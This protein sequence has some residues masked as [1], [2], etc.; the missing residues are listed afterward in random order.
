M[1]KKIILLSIFSL[2]LVSCKTDAKKSEDNSTTEKLYSIVPKTTK[3]GWTAYKT[4]DKVAVDGEFTKV[5]ITAKKATT[6]QELLNDLE[7]SIPVSSLFS[8]NE[9]RDTK[10][11]KLFFGVMENT[12]LLSGKI[13]VTS[14]NNG[15][16]TVTMNS[17]TNSFPIEYIKNGQMI[18]LSGVLNIDNFNGSK[19]MESLNKAC[20]EL[21]KGADGISKT[22]SDVAIKVATYV[23]IE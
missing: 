3:V 14:H 13:T 20:F 19:A 7:F 18:T 17:V 9:E 12:E 5:T 15:I 8:N 1:N 10:L 22:W 6:V 23:K 21:H 16:A 4:T 11:K 2:L